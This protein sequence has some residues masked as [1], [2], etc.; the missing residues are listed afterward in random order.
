[1]TMRTH[2]LG[3]L[4][5]E[6]LM[7][8]L[9]VL[10]AFV[11][12]G[13][14]DDREL[15]REVRQDLG[16]IEDELRR[17]RVGVAV[18]IGTLGRVV[19]GGEA[20]IHQ[21]ESARDGSVLVVPDTLLFLGTYWHPTYNASLGAVEAL[22]ASGRL[23]EIADPNLR[24]GLAGLNE[25]VADAL[26][27]EEFAR[28]VSVESLGPVLDDLV[29]L[30]LFEDILSDFFGGTG[31]GASPQARA[32]ELPIPS[33]GTVEIVTTRKVRNL[34]VRRVAWQRAAIGEFRRLDR[35]L[36]DLLG[37]LENELR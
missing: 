11:L 27:E 30:P 24:L 26:E 5:A 18:E 1:M 36:G 32:A 7:V 34:V 21:M 25:V 2:R 33:S 3:S 14:R 19:A 4:A 13:L 8:L 20:L 15:A 37:L 22:L 31:E 35:H 23:S 6:G 10:G 12:E 17:N 28:A 29:G 16:S 9:G